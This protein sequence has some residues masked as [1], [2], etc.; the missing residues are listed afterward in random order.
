MSDPQLEKAPTSV[1]LRDVNERL[2]ISALREQEMAITLEVE[3]ARLDAILSSIGDAVLVVDREGEP[4][5]TNA[6]YTRMMGDPEVAIVLEDASGKIIPPENAP[7]HRAARGDAFILEFS[8]RNPDGTPQWWEAHGEPIGHDSN[9]QGGVV[10]IRDVSERKRLEQALHHQT[11]HDALTGL[12]NRTLLYD[13]LD[14]T[15]R[16][17]QRT[18][19]PLALLLLDLDRF[20]EINDTFGHQ[21]GDLLLRKIAARLLLALRAADTVARIGGD[22]F[23]MLLPGTD[24]DGA[25]EVAGRILPS[26]STAVMIEGQ[27]VHVAVSVGI[28]LSSGWDTDVPTL[29][30]QADIAM[31]EAKRTQSGYAIYCAMFETTEP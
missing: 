9:A 25:V 13:R 4:V 26:L 23:V 8:I 14:Q 28:A 15:L 3:R 17:G 24:R 5:L 27:A 22:E 16:S 30:R 31:Y 19:D 10:I 18:D 7:W 1:E 11:L 20:K 12:P 6:A 2:L 29:L 21:A